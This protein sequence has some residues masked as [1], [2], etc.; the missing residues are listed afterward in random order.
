MEDA[1][2]HVLV[3]SDGS[4]LADKAIALALQDAGNARITALIVA[5][6]YGLAEYVRAAIGHR[7][8][9]QE[10]REEIAAG[11]RRDLEEALA[12]AGRGDPRIAQIERRVIISERSPSHEIVD[13]A[14]H[15]PCDLIVMASHGLGG[16]KMA[17]F[18]GSQ[19][20]AVLSAAKVPVLVAR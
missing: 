12:R 20:L 9:A 4:P 10:L 2:K 16:G 11:A 18:L 14:G 19:A 15:G 13:T 7:P 3:A 5:H 17:P 1:F 8:D 6:D